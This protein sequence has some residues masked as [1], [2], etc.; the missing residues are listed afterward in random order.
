MNR[1]SFL[2]SATSLALVPF[3]PLARIEPKEK[4]QWVVLRHTN[5][6]HKFDKDVDDFFIIPLYRPIRDIAK[7]KQQLI[8]FHL[9]EVG[10]NMKLYE[11]RPIGMPEHIGLAAFN[12]DGTYVVC[13]SNNGILPD[14]RHLL[15]KYKRE[16]DFIRKML[17]RTNYF[18]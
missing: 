10:P 7:E 16:A 5:V 12:T 6:I 11:V 8:D 9:A 17:N 14:T 18:G 13:A 4:Y 3:L 1:R 15:P 2:G